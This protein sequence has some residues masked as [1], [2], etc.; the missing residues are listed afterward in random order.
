MSVPKRVFI[1]PYRNR[2]PHLKAFKERITK[3][4]GDQIN[5]CH[6][7]VSHQCDQ[8]PFN[9]GA[10]KNIGFLEMR[11]RYPN[12]YKDITFI[13]HDVDNWPREDGLIPYETIDGVVAHYYG[14]EFALGG[15]FAIKGKDFEKTG[16]FPNFWGWGLEDNVM[17]ERCLQSGL[18]IDRT[19]F[20]RTSDRRIARPFD[21]FKRVMAKE[22]IVEYT[23]SLYDNMFHIMNIQV[24]DSSDMLNVLSFEVSKDWRKLEFMEKDIREGGKVRVPTIKTRRMKDWSMKLI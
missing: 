10:M 23:N 9:R 8:R 12:H 19:C 13:F 24:C 7:C 11:R 2:E 5:E 15:I 14:F 22:E 4:L 17:N 18:K 20:F 1:V 21:G 16:G 6:I 3:Y